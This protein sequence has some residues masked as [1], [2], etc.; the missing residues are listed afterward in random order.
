VSSARTL[1]G[2]SSDRKRKRE[3][4]EN[5]DRERKGGEQS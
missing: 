1:A 4:G 3:G 5:G 2:Q